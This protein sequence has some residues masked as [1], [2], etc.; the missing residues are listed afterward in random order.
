MCDLEVRPPLLEHSKDLRLRVQEIRSLSIELRSHAQIQQKCKASCNTLVPARDDVILSHA[1][2]T[3][4]FLVVRQAAAVM[5]LVVAL[6]FRS[7]G[8][9]DQE[10]IPVTVTNFSTSTQ[11]QSVEAADI[12]APCHHGWCLR[13]LPITK[14]GCLLLQYL[15][16]SCACWGT[17]TVEDMCYEI[18]RTCNG[19]DS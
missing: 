4:S 19:A 16:Q 14:R 2:I 17:R 6:F 8:T 12:E 11:T 3:C 13:S 1:H 5:Q 9:R 15:M 7:S 18:Q 10:R